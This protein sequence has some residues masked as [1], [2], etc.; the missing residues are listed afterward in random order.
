MKTIRYSDLTGK[1][2]NLTQWEQER[3]ERVQVVAEAVSAVHPCD[4]MV[5]AEEYDSGVHLNHIRPMLVH[6][7]QIAIWEEENELLKF[8][9]EKRYPLVRNSQVSGLTLPNRV[10]LKAITERK[11][12]QW[13]EFIEAR[14][15]VLSER[16]RE[17]EAMH[18]DFM[19]RIERCGVPVQWSH[20]NPKQGWVQRGGMVLEFELAPGTV[21]TK[22]RLAHMDHSLDQWQRMTRWAAT[23]VAVKEVEE[24][25]I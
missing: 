17:T 25:V 12:M 16:Q 24:F 18:E 19:W 7:L 8:T 4:V 6:P 23:E 2:L 1:S 13:V 11:V 10:G 3:L 14:H 22:I 5:D 15:M 21:Y 20:N 9:T